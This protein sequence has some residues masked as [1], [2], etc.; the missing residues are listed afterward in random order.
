MNFK[1]KITSR[2]D[3]LQEEFINIRRHLHKYPELSFQEYKTSA[4]ICQ[5]LEEYGIEYKKGIAETGVLGIIKCKNPNKKVI[6]LRAD[7]DALPIQE[8]TN[9]EFKSVNENVMHACGHDLHTACLLGASKILKELK[10]EL[11][12]TLLLLF[13]PGEEL[14][15][16]GARLMLDQGVFSDIKPNYIIA[17]HVLPDMK[18][19]HVGYKS[20]M[21]MASGDEIY[22]NIK[23]QGGHGALPHKLTDT[24]LVASHIIVAL[25]QIVSRNGNAE[26]PTVL[27]FGKIEANGATNIIPDEVKI[28][29]TLRTMD[30]SWRKQAKQLINQIAQNTAKAMGRNVR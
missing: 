14:L 30:E 10:E 16:G 2:V 8:E 28:A 19:G 29:G 7:I 23:G 24:V 3:S 6:A 9:L 20:G 22:L 17:Q 5:K 11:E 26:I 27:S 15:P 25:Q 1:E 12:G 21:Y 13:Q 18:C 4:Y